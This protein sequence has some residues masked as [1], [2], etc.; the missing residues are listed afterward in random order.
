MARLSKVDAA[1]AASVSRQTLYAYLKSGRLSA[2]PDGLIDTAELLRAGFALHTG[3][4]SG[5]PVL[6]TLRQ[7]LTS[8]L[9]TVTS[10]LDTLDVY[11][12]ML[13]TLKRQLADAQAR[14]QAALER[15]HHAREREAVLLQMVQ[16]MQQR[17]DRLL[18]IPRTPPPSP[19]ESPGTTQRHTRPESPP[20]RQALPLDEPPAAQGGDPRGAMRRRIVAL[21]QE[22]PKGLTP[23]EM[24]T[25]LGVYKSLG[26]TLLGML[27]YGLVQRVGRGRYVATAPSRTD[28]S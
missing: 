11:R 19:Q 10:S 16:D 8:N 13:D 3:H 14:E 2:D 9:D 22:H 17:Y 5:R 12:D 1:K 18:D 24:R 23:T 25:M 20:T 15:E 6:D 21:L 26:D 7:P 28:Q 4:E 27:R